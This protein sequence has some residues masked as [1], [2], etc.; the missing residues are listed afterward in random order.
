M[1]KRIGIPILSQ[2]ISNNRFIDIVVV[3]S[4]IKDSVDP[5]SVFQL[6]HEYEWAEICM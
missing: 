3:Y 5:V 6:H 4:I 2:L 1:Y